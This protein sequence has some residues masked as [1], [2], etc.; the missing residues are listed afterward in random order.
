[1]KPAHLLVSLS[2]MVCLVATISKADGI[3]LT[4]EDVRS[5]VGAFAVTL[6]YGH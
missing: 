2:L 6:H 3:Q 5:D 1:M 4:V